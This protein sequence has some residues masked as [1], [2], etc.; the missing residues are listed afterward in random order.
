M[1]PKA[2][3]I[4]E[5]ARPKPRLFAEFTNKIRGKKAKKGIFEKEISEEEL[6]VVK[7]KIREK[8]VRINR[9]KLIFRLALITALLI[10]V[11]FIGQNFF[12]SNE[13]ETEKQQL[14]AYEKRQ[15]Y[16]IE[17]YRCLQMNEFYRARRYF[18]RASDI[19]PDD[20]R[21]QL[22]FTKTYISLCKYY[23]VDCG[24][25]AKS[26]QALKDVYG[27]QPGIK[28]VTEEFMQMQE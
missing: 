18:K 9:R 19:D 26:L 12:Q 28:K 24:K 4:R 14:K 3:I 16:I 6:D 2:E 1:K 27:N 20:Y 11:F 17:G 5:N 7:T 25:A 13:E 21:L 22:G 23:N 10:P 15:K 8:M